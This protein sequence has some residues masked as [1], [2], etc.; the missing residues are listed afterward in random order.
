M[1]RKSYTP[2]QIIKVFCATGAISNNSD[3]CVISPHSTLSHKVKFQ[4]IAN[5]MVI[6]QEVG[7]F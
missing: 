2:E 1:A 7:T 4:E 5:T 6:P 3:K